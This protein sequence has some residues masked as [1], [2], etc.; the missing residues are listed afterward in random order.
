M[1]FRQSCRCRSF[2]LPNPGSRMGCL[3]K[4]GGWGF[5]GNHCRTIVRVPSGPTFR[6]DLSISI[7]PVSA[8]NSDYSRVET[9]VIKLVDTFPIVLNGSNSSVGVSIQQVASGVC[10]RGSG[11]DGLSLDTC[12]RDL[13]GLSGFGSGG[14][15]VK[16]AVSC[17]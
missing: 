16:S 3:R 11:L 4:K 6:K 13:F 15:L 1:P 17:V 10:D 8:S 5:V 7:S 9:D 14:L 12:E 2:P